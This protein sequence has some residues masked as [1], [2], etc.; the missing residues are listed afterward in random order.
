MKKKIAAFLA[1]AVVATLGFLGTNAPAV[2]ATGY[3]SASCTVSDGIHPAQTFKLTSYLNT[4]GTR[5]WHWSGTGGT[6]NFPAPSVVWQFKYAYN[7][8]TGST[9]AGTEGYW[10]SANTGYIT[11]T[12]T[13]RKTI[14]TNSYEYK[15][16][17]TA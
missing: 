17:A 14:A 9:Y 10:T 12:G 4:D 15:C 16:S 3:R 7:G 6:Y 2:A 5:T 8:R 11:W 13:W 1:A